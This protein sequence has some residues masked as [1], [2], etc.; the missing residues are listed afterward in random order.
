MACQRTHAV[1]EQPAR[2]ARRFL[3]FYFEEGIA[4]PRVLLSGAALLLLAWVVPAHASDKLK[5]SGDKDTRTLQF[6]PATDEA[7]TVQTWGHG[8]CFHGGCFHGG[9]CRPFCGGGFCRPFC[10]GG[11]C[12]SGFGC[13]APRFSCGFGC[14]RPFCFGGFRRSWFWG[15]SFFPVA[16]PFVNSV[17]F[18][19]G[20][21]S[22]PSVVNAP[23]VTP[24][25]PSLRA[26]P[27][28]PDVAPRAT[29][30]QNDGTFPYDGGPRSP[31]PMPRAEPAPMST[32]PPSVPLEG[33]SVSLPPT[34]VAKY[35]YPA[36]GD[37]PTPTNSNGGVLVKNDTTKKAQR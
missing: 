20:V 7:E 34:K 22:F 8:G 5:V 2:G 37:Q 12:R 21:S 33:R 11:F 25:A 6:N 18:S 10:G 14:A 4:M 31:V 23:E 36:Y 28:L 30:Y 15:P 24:F 3:S 27:L 29:P 32:P 26:Q 9:F 19:A 17:S 35:A 13:F 1:T 16:T